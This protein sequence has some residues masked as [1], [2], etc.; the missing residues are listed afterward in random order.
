M[1]LV[2]RLGKL[3]LIAAVYVLG[4]LVLDALLQRLVPI[5]VLPPMFMD[6]ARWA[7]ALTLVVLLAAAWVHG[8]PDE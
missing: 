6:L 5:L 3:A 1:A 8:R 4:A 2:G 7:M